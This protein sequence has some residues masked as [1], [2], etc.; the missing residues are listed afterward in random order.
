VKSVILIMPNEQFFQNMFSVN[1]SFFARLFDGHF[2]DTGNIECQ[3][4]RYLQAK[5]E[6]FMKN[7]NYAWNSRFL[8][9]QRRCPEISINILPG[10]QFPDFN[11]AHE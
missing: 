1:V 6:Q 4:D 5:L 10:C 8:D 3:P 11:K 7:N 9:P 2:P